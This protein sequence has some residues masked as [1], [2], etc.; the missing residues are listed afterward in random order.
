MG[1]DSVHFC[2]VVE[3]FLISSGWVVV[4]KYTTVPTSIER[5]GTT[6]KAFAA[7]VKEQV[8]ALQCHFVSG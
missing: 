2:V 3:G 5:T 8:T 7:L 1:W 6:V 4:H